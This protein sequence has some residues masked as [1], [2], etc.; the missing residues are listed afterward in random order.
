M[1]QFNVFNIFRWS[2]FLTFVFLALHLGAV[3]WDFGRFTTSHLRPFVYLGGSISTLYEIF[4]VIFLVML[5]VAVFSGLLIIL[6]AFE[7]LDTCPNLTGCGTTVPDAASDTSSDT[8]VVESPPPTPSRR[9]RRTGCK[10]R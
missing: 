6:R 7:S 4:A 3:Y 2:F 10:A 5:L 8:T 9:G 1:H